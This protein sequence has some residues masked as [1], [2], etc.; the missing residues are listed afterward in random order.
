MIVH[1]EAVFFQCARAII[2]SRLWGTVE[3]RRDLPSPGEVLAHLSQQRLGSRARMETEQLGFCFTAIT[4]ET[5]QRS[6]V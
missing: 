1:V 5:A 2:R 3:E 6:G 4:A